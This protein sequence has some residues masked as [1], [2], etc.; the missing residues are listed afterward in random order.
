MSDT[1]GAANHLNKVYAGQTE[2]EVAR[3]YD[4]WAKTYDNDVGVAG[5]RHPMVCLGLVTRHVAPDAGP[6]LDAG[7]G[8]GLVGDWLKILGYKQLEAL[9]GSEGMNEIARERGCYDAV[10]LGLLGH[11]LSI[12]DG[13]YAAA[14]VAGVFT[15]GHAGT[16]GLDH[17]LRLVRPGGHIVATV[18]N[19]LY[20]SGFG[21]HL[22]ELIRAG[23]CEEVERT[24]DYVSMPNVP[25][26]SAGRAYVLRVR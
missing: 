9:D 5:Y 15:P 13:H 17:L 8:T 1:P 18:K 14:V 19:E 16:E 4:E 23:R 25:G 11:D 24:V 22:N 26:H 10:H 2:E 12:E 20:D 7:S 21:D 3:D 6:I